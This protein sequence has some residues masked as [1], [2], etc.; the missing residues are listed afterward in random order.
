[1]N[2]VVMPEMVALHDDTA[3]SLVLHAGVIVKVLHADGF[4]GFGWCGR[5]RRRWSMDLR[6]GLIASM[7]STAGSR[8]VAAALR[9]RT[10]KR[11]LMWTAFGRWQIGE[12][13]RAVIRIKVQ[14]EVILDRAGLLRWQ[15]IAVTCVRICDSGGIEELEILVIDGAGLA[16]LLP[17]FLS[18]TASMC[19]KYL[20]IRGKSRIWLVHGRDP[21]SL[22]FR[23]LLA[24]AGAAAQT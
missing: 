17:L 1:M 23:T 21:W 14:V 24:C 2:T 8:A 11:Q 3:T 22:A 7:I 12:F 4:S 9:A 5:S 19:G 16:F 18:E 13:G 20:L 10:A 6:H 15:V